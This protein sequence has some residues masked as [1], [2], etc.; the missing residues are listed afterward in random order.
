MGICGVMVRVLPLRG[1]MV[2]VLPS[3]AV[4]LGFEP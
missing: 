3:R 1:V 4:D 2:R